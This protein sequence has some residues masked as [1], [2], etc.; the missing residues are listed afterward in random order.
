MCSWGGCQLSYHSE[1]RIGL[2][3]LC[4]RHSWHPVT[5]GGC[6]SCCAASRR[7]A[8]PAAAPLSFCCV[9]RTLSSCCGP[10]RFCCFPVAILLCS[11]CVPDALLLRPQSFSRK[12]AS[13][14]APLGERRQLEL[15]LTRTKWVG[16]SA[17]KFTIFCNLYDDRSWNPSTTI[18]VNLANHGC[19]SSAVD[20]SYEKIWCSTHFVFAA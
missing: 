18:E 7:C 2:P 20:N 12:L 8:P 17:P 16:G 5:Q 13:L 1:E 9:L 11:C 4:R 10:S 15:L 19:D 3:V 6:K 14:G